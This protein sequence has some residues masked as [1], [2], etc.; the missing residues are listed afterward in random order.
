MLVL[1]RKKGESIVIAGDIEITILG[2]EGDAV[3]VGIQAPRHIQIHRKEVYLSIQ[4][5]NQEA[6]HA[7]V[8]L[9][10]MQMLFKQKK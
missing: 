6:A 8:D 1:T 10:T 4:E 2:S 3:K 5:S 9:N 7:K